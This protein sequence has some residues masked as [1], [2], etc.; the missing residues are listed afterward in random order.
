MTSNRKYHYWQSLSET[1]TNTD[2]HIYYIEL[3]LLL[4]A[5]NKKLDILR[6]I[7]NV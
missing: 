7:G 4:P 2:I 3:P 1:V 5:L 6:D